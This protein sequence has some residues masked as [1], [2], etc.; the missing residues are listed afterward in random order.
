MMLCVL[1]A[2]IATSGCAQTVAG[3]AQQVCETWRSISIS[4]NDKLTDQ[5][6]KEI[7]GNNAARGAW[8]KGTS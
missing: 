7:A 8:C 6:A 2:G 3:T 5:T 1:T 4:K